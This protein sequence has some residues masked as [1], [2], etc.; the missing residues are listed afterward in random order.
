[1]FWGVPTEGLEVQNARITEGI[2]GGIHEEFSGETLYEFLENY[3]DKSL[4]EL[5]QASP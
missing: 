5:M 4:K 2:S 1:M 3:L